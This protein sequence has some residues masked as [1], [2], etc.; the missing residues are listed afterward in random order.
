VTR[1]SVH[2]YTFLLSFGVTAAASAQTIFNA[3][4]DNGF[5]T[6]FSSAT[7]SNVRYG[8]SGWLT[9]GGSAPIGLRDITLGLAVFS[10]ANGAAPGQTDLT[11][12]FNDGDPSG[13]VFG[14]GSTLYTVTIQNIALPASDGITPGFLYLTIPLPGVVTSGNFNNVGWS[15]GVQN[16]NYEGSFGFQVSSTLAQSVGFYTNNASFYNGT[17]WSLFAF[18][19]DPTF[20][21]ANF[22]A[23]ITVPSPAAGLAMFGLAGVVARRRR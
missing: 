11:F 15:V 13:L 18:S 2:A 17:S 20:G 4:P 6:P 14:P 3:G 10:G 9:N 5:F 19:G 12:T 16:F 8:D 1:P 21:V 7:S 23:E 22:V